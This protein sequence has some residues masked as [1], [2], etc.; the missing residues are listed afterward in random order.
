MNTEVSLLRLPDVLERVGLSRS[1]LYQLV[2][3]GRF[4][5]PVA[6]SSRAVGWSSTAIAD[7]IQDRIATA[8]RAERGR[9]P[10]QMAA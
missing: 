3:A 6:L 7:W 2:A 10:T 1:S 9:A 4:P 8:Q 5:K